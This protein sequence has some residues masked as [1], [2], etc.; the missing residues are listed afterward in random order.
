MGQIIAGIFRALTVSK[1]LSCELDVG[2]VHLDGQITVLVSYSRSDPVD[3]A[4]KV[5]AISVFSFCS[6]FQA[7][8]S[9]FYQKFMFSVVFHTSIAKELMRFS[10][11]DLDISLAEENNIPPDF[12]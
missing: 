7:V 12:R 4:S 6:Y 3:P 8:L 5:G 11:S 2:D 10:R 1:S 9:F